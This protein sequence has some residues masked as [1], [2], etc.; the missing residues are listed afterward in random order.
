M[1]VRLDISMLA[2]EW[3][4]N[5]PGSISMLVRALIGFHIGLGFQSMRVAS[6]GV[7][8]HSPRKEGLTRMG[9]GRRGRAS[10][11]VT[12]TRSIPIGDRV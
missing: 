6:P 7:S 8:L 1:L 3:H 9:H 4:Q 5:Q 12:P 10:L 11:P 2:G